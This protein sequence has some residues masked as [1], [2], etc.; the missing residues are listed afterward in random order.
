MELDPKAV[1]VGRL[2]QGAHLVGGEA[3]P[4]AKGVDRR[5]QPG[6]GHRRDHLLDRH[7]D[8]IL[9]A[10]AMLGRQA[11]AAP[12][13]SAPTRTASLSPSALAASSIFIS[14]GTSRP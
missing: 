2:E 5:R 9:A 8:I 1:L 12:A 11:R 4:L 3:D 10:V 14:L 13:G 6:L 7:P